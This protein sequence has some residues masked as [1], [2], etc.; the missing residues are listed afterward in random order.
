MPKKI[1]YNTNMRGINHPQYCK[2]NTLRMSSCLKDSWSLQCKDQLLFTK[3]FGYFLY[4]WP[5]SSDKHNNI[6]SIPKRKKW[7]VKEAV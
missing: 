5:P 7:E 1:K 4:E 2:I 3:C 6:M